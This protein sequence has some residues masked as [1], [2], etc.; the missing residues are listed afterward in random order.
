[1]AASQDRGIVSNGADMRLSTWRAMSREHT[2][3]GSPR[4]SDC[5]M[6]QSTNIDMEALVNMETKG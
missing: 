5:F 6:L 3:R 4:T 1:M 2:S